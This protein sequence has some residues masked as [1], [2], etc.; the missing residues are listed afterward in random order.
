[1]AKWM[2]GAVKRHG[3]LTKK[4]AAAGESPMQFAREHA[5][6]PGLTGQEARFALTAQKEP[7]P[8]DRGKER[9]RRVY[10]HPTSAAHRGDK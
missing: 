6:S 8:E 4:A 10:K 1:M 3:A 9:R 7:I 2:K 5:H